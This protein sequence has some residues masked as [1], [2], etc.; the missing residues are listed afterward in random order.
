MGP[1]TEHDPLLSAWRA[2]AGG[3]V[4]AGWRTIPLVALGGCKLFAG[5]QFPGNEEALLVE[6]P[7][8][9]VPP[10][11]TLPQG[12]GFS[13]SRA[14]VPSSHPMGVML[15]LSR[16]GPGGLDMF[17]MVARDVLGA[18]ETCG[19]QDGEGLLH[20]FIARMRAWQHFMEKG[21]ADTLSSDAEI[22]LFGELVVL[23]G[24]LAGGA[25]ASVAIESW[26]GPLD[27][28][29]DFMTRAAAM[30]VKTTIAT[31]GFTAL[32]G[33]LEQLDDAHL[34]PLFLAAVRLSLSSAG[35]TLP[36]VIRDVRAVLRC[37]PAAAADFENRVLRAGFLDASSGSY[38]RAF[39]HSSTMLFRVAPGFPR[40]TR[41]T[42]PPA[43]TK[44]RYELEL[45]TWSGEQ[46]GMDSV[47]V[48]LGMR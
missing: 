31:A 36:Q 34:Q 1:L 48:E 17:S 43:I 38:T 39:G 19:M 23:E 14:E 22:G 40:L 28:V 8:A 33:S 47:L 35:R 16:R 25:A 27:G 11:Q 18:M 45:S 2:L 32:I 12:N 6:F 5:R 20:V 4:S 46:L 15:A 42:V 10:T 30:E 24:L 37:D 44:A 29:Q 13:V 7:F 9:H 21:G 3:D 26:K 41:S